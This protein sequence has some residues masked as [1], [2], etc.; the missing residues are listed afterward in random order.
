MTA[1]PED[2]EAHIGHVHSTMGG[3]HPGKE[4][5]VRGLPLHQHWRSGR[6]FDIY[7]FAL[8]GR[9]YNAAE[10]E[11]LETIWTYTSYPDPRIWNNRVAA[12]AGSGHAS[13]ALA[14]GA[15]IA[16]TDA[17]LYGIRPTIEAYDFLAA[18]AGDTDEALLAA[19]EEEL[20]ANRRLAGYGRP[21]VAEDERIEPLMKRADELG[22]DGGFHVQAAFR[23]ERM[24]AAGRWRL[25][26]NYAALV[27]G[28]WLDM[29]MMRHECE[30][31]NA[32]AFLA[33]MPP[34]WLEARLQAP[35]LLFPIPLS[36]VA[37]E[38]PAVRSWPSQS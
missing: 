26:M 3:F 29:G 18:H 12:L 11:L 37:Y 7:L 13:V 19:I 22:L 4:V 23:I 15:A 16:V 2:Y 24:L 14:L 17:G 10:T 32:T 27:A 8:T 33:G 1:K 5:Y 28:F 31:L 38:G 9:Q 20:R 30:A 21:I 25:K 35:G 6:W 34:V 36:M